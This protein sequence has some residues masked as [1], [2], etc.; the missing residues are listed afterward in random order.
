MICL[1]GSIEQ[2]DLETVLVLSGERVQQGKDIPAGQEFVKAV[3]LD[4][5]RNSII[6]IHATLVSVRRFN[7]MKWRTNQFLMN[8]LKE[9]RGYA[10]RDR[11]RTANARLVALIMSIH[12]TL[13][14]KTSL[15]A[16]LRKGLVST[17]SSLK[18]NKRRLHV[19]IKRQYLNLN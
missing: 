12:P 15:K 9:E 3:R 2:E 1:L 5:N 13:T 8:W 11:W 19:M 18:Q 7:E 4:E 10:S 17:Q 6:F 14:W 16:R